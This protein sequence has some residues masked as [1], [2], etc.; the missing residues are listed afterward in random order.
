MT[1]QRTDGLSYG[2]LGEAF[3]D[4]NNGQWLFSHQFEEGQIV[5]LRTSSTAQLTSCAGLHLRPIGFS[6]TSIPS[7]ELFP[8]GQQ[9]HVS[10]QALHQRAK[11]VVAKYPELVPGLATLESFAHTSQHITSLTSIHDP[12]ISDQLVFGRAVDLDSQNSGARTIPI[13]AVAAGKAGDAVRLV[14]VELARHGWRRH[15]EVSLAVPEIARGEEGWW[16]GNSGPIQQ[17]RCAE[18]AGESSTWMAIRLLHSTVILHPLY[19]RAPV[20]ASSAEGVSTDGRFPPSRLD[21]NPVLS[22]PIGQTGGVPHADVNFNPWYQRQIA[23]VD[24]HGTWSI[25]D[26]EGQERKRVTYE[27]NAGK[28][29]HIYDG[30]EMGNSHQNNADGWGAI[31]VAGNVNTLVVCNR[32]HMAVF[33]VSGK[34][35]RLGAP[36]LGLSRNSDWILDLRR[37]SRNRS[38]IFVLT[39]S[40]ITWLHVTGACEY[41]G[42]D[43][44]KTGATNLLSWCHFRDGEDTGLRLH[45]IERGGGTICCYMRSRAAQLNT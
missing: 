16:V 29:G 41:H 10:G 1:E 18:L 35:N 6:A 12:L 38:H 7:S 5:Q 30:Y 37:S 32:R 33:D 8:E 15:E 2:H 19:H 39:S 14:R 28:V 34:P 3:Y 23:V 40:R 22:L 26:L 21:A 11:S 25:W 20:A 31:C 4:T 45:V 43:S 13:I 9:E 36:D 44:P 27:L 24:Q 17:I 42:I